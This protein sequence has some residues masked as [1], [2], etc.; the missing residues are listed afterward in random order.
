MKIPRGTADEPL[1]APS[2]TARWASPSEILAYHYKIGDIYLGDAFTAPAAAEEVIW[3]LDAL[4][5]RIA[6]FNELDHAWAVEQI[7]HA[8]QLRD[9]LVTFERF[10]VG[11]DDDR[12]LI[13]VAGSRSGKGVSAIIPNLCRYPGSIVCIDPKGSNARQTAT[14]RGRGSER[15]RGMGQKSLVLDPYRISGVPKELRASFNPLER[16]SPDSFE[17]IDEASSLAQGLIVRGSDESSH[18]DD[19]ARSLVKAL[20]LYVVLNAPE[21]K[22]TLPYVHTLLTQGARDQMKAGRGSGVSA[23]GEPDPFRY[24]LFMMEQE[25]RLDGVIAG[26]AATLLDMGEREYGSV[27]STARRNLE[28]L[29]RPGIREVLSRSTFS[30]DELKASEKG[31]TIYLCL[32]VTRMDDCGRW[33]RLMIAAALERIYA[34]PGK[35]ACGHPILFLLEEF[36]TLKHMEVIETAA[37]YAAEFGVKLWAILQD[38]S[39]L[40]RHYKHGWETFLGNASVVQAFGN[41][42]M[43]TLDYLS[44]KLGETETVQ[45]TRNTTTSRSV[46]SNDAGD[47]LRL[48]KALRLNPLAHLSLLA[49]QRAIGESAT[50]TTALNQQIQ[51]APLMQTNEIEQVFRREEMTEIVSIKGERPFALHRQAFHESPD[52]AGLFEPDREP[53][54]TIEEAER[55]RA[56]SEKRHARNLARTILAAEKFISDMTASLDAAEVARTKR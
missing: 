51:R 20:I 55:W 19:T 28:F 14:R 13:T 47:G 10:P 54:R 11:I 40:Q 39:Q 16:L 48:E 21:R 7:A 27:L 29:E 5:E 44:R 26:I 15:C 45:V 30:L 49:D 4:I 9:R 31:V 17:I 33:L 12:H 35:P 32:P 34:I 3:A 24:L 46:S 8:R 6:S 25:N 50:T 41:S 2:A 43:T 23:P 22:R 36:A 38:I 42:D 1:T 18:F 56:E 52:F 53:Y 37:G